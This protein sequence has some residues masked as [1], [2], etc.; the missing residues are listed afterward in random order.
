[1]RNMQLWAEAYLLCSP[2]RDPAER[3]S[4]NPKQKKGKKEKLKY[5]FKKI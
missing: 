1:M 2:T 4:L 5:N 3:A